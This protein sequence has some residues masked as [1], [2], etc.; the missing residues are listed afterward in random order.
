MAT[1]REVLIAT[2]GTQPEVVTV[3]L[4]LLLEQGCDIQEVVVIHTSSSHP[5]IRESLRRLD[6]E[7]PQGRLYAHANIPC[8]YRKLELK[9]EGRRIADIKTWKEAG[10]VFTTIYREVREQKRRGSLIH[11]CIAGGRKS[12]SV[13]GMATAQLLFDAEDRL[14]HLFSSKTFEEANLM[15][16]RYP[17]DAQLVPIPLLPYRALSIPL[18]TLLATDDPLKAV[19]EQ[20]KLIRL[21]ERRRQREFIE[22]A[23]SAPERRVVE[24]L[25][26]EVI[27][28]HRSPTNEEIGRKI[29]LAPHTVANALTRVYD[30]LRLFLGLPEEVKVDRTLL[31]A[32]FSSY[33]AERLGESQP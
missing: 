5:E 20:R 32:L 17:G 7:F 19:E 31:A 11:L 16:P 12:M 30:K 23:L 8:L 18:A 25:V 9:V 4:D 21:E 15:H 24:A 6:D 29:Y 2:L 26:E 22:E 13:Y 3:A 27:V 14:W 10:A 1:R 33:F 28:H